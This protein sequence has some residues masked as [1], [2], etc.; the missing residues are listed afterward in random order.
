MLHELSALTN[1]K[2]EPRLYILHANARREWMTSCNSNKISINSHISKD[3]TIMLVDCK[4]RLC[5]KNLLHGN[6]NE[7]CQLVSNMI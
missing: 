1:G 5:M 3:I 4:P 6:K 2:Y 7:R